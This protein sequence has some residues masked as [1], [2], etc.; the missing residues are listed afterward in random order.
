MEKSSALVVSAVTQAQNVP[1]MQHHTPASPPL[2]HLQRIGEAGCQTTATHLRL[3]RHRE[4][5]WI[6]IRRKLEVDCTW[7]LVNLG[8]R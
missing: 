1:A 4:R 5:H 7:S 2:Q 8:M 6:Y 3:D